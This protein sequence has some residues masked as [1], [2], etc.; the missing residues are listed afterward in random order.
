M[1]RLYWKIVLTELVFMVLILAVAV[2]LIGM[3]HKDDEISRQDKRA[4]AVQ[5]LNV[6]LKNDLAHEVSL[7]GLEKLASRLFKGDV[8]IVESGKIG[9]ADATDSIQFNQ[10]GRAYALIIPGSDVP[11]NGKGGFLFFP[12]HDKYG[13]VLLVLAA[14]LAL[15]AVPFARIVTGPLGELRH[16]MRLFASGDLAHRTKVTSQD[17]VGQVARDFNEMAESIQHLVR[18][19]KEMTA[20][21]SHELR[22]P[23][24]RI[25]VARQVLEEQVS[26]KQLVLLDSM[27]EEIEGMDALIERM[28][29]FSRLELDKSTP[30]PLCFVDIFN[31]LLRRHEPSFEA[32]GI[33]LHSV[34][35]ENLPG[36]GAAGDIGCLGDNLLGNA[37]K[38]TPPGGNVEIYLGNEHGRIIIS[39]TNDAEQPSVNMLR[40]TEAFQR[41]GASESI[42]GSGLGLAIVQRIVENHGGELLLSWSDGKFSVSVE[43]PAL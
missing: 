40:L 2:W 6:A 28:L 14:A 25:D 9:D 34:F 18:V 4:A 35:P 29:R 22:S 7:V 11:R 10:G 27:R 32:K 42:P 38:F 43:L 15:L 31:E 26:G 36:V 3:S 21:V 23:L 33:H 37:L 30:E 13:S 8:R 17:E 12:D 24:T 39:V 20:H 41:G 16:D 5:L 1:K 19:G